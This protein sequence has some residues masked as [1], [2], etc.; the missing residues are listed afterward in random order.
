[1][2]HAACW[3]ASTYVGYTQPWQVILADPMGGAPGGLSHWAKLQADIKWWMQ[4]HAR[5]CSYVFHFKYVEKILREIES[6]WQFVYLT[7]LPKQTDGC[8]CS[9]ITIMYCLYFGMGYVPFSD[10]CFQEVHGHSIDLARVWEWCRW[11][12]AILVTDGRILAGGSTVD[13]GVGLRWQS[14]GN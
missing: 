6:E 7:D 12:A 5:N 11:F 1:M 4:N 3:Y 10:G 2:L 14:L 9:L 8:S 13:Y